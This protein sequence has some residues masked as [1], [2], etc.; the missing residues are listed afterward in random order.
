MNTLIE[1][2]LP[3]DVYRQCILPHFHLLSLRDCIGD[4][5]DIEIIATE[6]AQ[7]NIAT[8]K[9]KM[10]AIMATIHGHNEVAKYFVYRIT[11]FGAKSHY[12]LRWA[13]ENGHLEVV[14][15][16]VSQGVHSHADMD[17]VLTIAS[18]NGHLE[19]VKYLVNAGVDQPFSIS[20]IY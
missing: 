18:R 2:K 9:Q 12:A 20:I 13:S 8:A 16:L 19:V 14:K 5:P 17:Y 4:Y 1:S 3:V 11:D 6:Y 10:E 7:W 15:Y